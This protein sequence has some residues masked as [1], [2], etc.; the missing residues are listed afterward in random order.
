[1]TCDGVTRR[2]DKKL[3]DRE[4]AERIL[5]PWQYF[6]VSVLWKGLHIKNRFTRKEKDSVISVLH[7]IST[8]QTKY[9][10][11]ASLICLTS[12]DCSERGSCTSHTGF[13]LHIS[14]SDLT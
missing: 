5:N 13:W 6:D 3:Q 7:Q 8:G 11:S 4:A 10:T 9:H 14:N 12:Q 2:Q 1:M